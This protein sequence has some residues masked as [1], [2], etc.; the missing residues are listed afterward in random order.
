MKPEAKFHLRKRKKLGAVLGLTLDAG[1]LE[2]VVLRRTN[3]SLQRLQSFSAPLTLDPLTAAPELV[4]REIRNQLDAAGVRERNCVVGLPLKWVMTAQTEL[5]PLPDADADSLLQLEAEKG[6]HTDAA[7]LQIANSRSALAGDKKFAL[8]A[9]VPTAQVAALEKVLA[10]AKL[11]PMSFALGISAL[12]SG[13]GAKSG[14][15][16]LVVGETSIGLQITASGGVVALR[17]L[18]GALETEG[19]RRTLL[20]N[21]VT[22]EARVTLGQLPAELREQ[23]K[24][25]RIYGPR[26]LAQQL[27][28]EMEL[29]FEPLGLT[30]DVVAAY[31]P[32]EFGV[33]LPADASVSP[34]FS[35]AARQL[36]Q[37]IPPFDFLPPKPTLLEQFVAKYSSGRLRTT[38][39]I[40][41]GVGAIVL[42]L[43]LAQQVQLWHF[44]A[45]WSRMAAKV[46]DLQHVQDQI[47][48][49]RS[50]YGGTFR[51]LAILREL[52]LAF[53]EDG[54]V[55]AKVIG[56]RDDGMVNCSG[57]MQD[58]SALLA[59]EAK[60][61]KAP[62][63]SNL[64]VEQIRGK[65][66]MQF[67]FSFKY[68]EAGGAQ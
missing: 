49:Y 51:N 44:R 56:I 20:P 37:Q 17:A 18:E 24:Q 30:V 58:N 10:A 15:L 7:E 65:S 67:V 2:G 50:W 38:G 34:A 59:M 22:R 5:P 23:V 52:S 33:T 46:T 45:Q 64:K 1:K 68:N 36:T 57:T 13:A 12:Q 62:G 39:A 40:A 8:L 54:V 42:A 11:K 60:L 28:D 53:P 6:F 41:V 47:R 16:A 31:A 66:P 9:G 29:R 32:N 35:L 19:A 61:A 26:E 48:Q 3:G 25:I 43:F 14:V 27:A 21:I 55:T 63:V 4:G